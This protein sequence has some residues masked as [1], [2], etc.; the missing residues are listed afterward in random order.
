MY[1]FDLISF[2]L[3]VPCRQLFYDAYKIH[4]WGH[5]G[6]KAAHLPNIGLA[7]GSV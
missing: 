5:D 6:V 2:V 1:A 7:S 4:K 3:Q